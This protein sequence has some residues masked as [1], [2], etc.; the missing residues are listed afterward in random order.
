MQ[1][2]ITL[3]L[4]ALLASST[5]VGQQAAFSINVANDIFNLFDQSDRYFTSGIELKGYHSRF[6]KSPLNLVL[7]NAGKSNPRLSGLFLQQNIY[8]PSNIHI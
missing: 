5:L 2:V 8:T 3:I 6:D 4:V 1:K 7:I